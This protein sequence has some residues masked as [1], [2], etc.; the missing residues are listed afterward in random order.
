MRLPSSALRFVAFLGISSLFFSG[1]STELDPN[2]DYKETMVI[3]G[4][5]DPSQRT[6]YIKVNKAFLNTNTNALTIAANNPDSTT[7]GENLEVKLQQLRSDSSLIQEFTLSPFDTASKE[8]G[9]FFGP[10]QRL[11]RTKGLTLDQNAI[12][13]VV[14]VN[15]TS[16][17]TASGA[18]K[19][20]KDFNP[21]DGK[22]FCI[23]RISQ[24]TS[25][26]G[27]CFSD[28]GVVTTY[29]P[30]LKSA[31]SFD[32]AQNAAIYTISMSFDY[33][34][35]TDGV[36]VDKRAS[37]QVRNNFLQTYTKDPLS[38]PIDE[39][40]FYTNL[41]GI[42]N[43]QND[44][45]ST[46]RKPGNVYVTVTAGSESLATNHLVN[47]SFSIFSQVR[48]Q[49]DNIK[50]GTGLVGSRLAKTVT[51]VLSDKAAD[52]L[53]LSHKYRSLKFVK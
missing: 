38:I 14:A 45:P 4:L 35:S 28:N 25:P 31:I 39:N 10:T 15:K 13:R 12:Y 27:Q 50:N 5:L 40:Y 37:W 29:D 22:R 46:F 18:T 36:T 3:Y 6:H 16:G 11:Y 34:E 26:V 23:F 2:A 33:K 17:T 32:L 43:T 47:T 52:T 8:P 9:T 1:C 21:E 48:P 19:L 42:I 24:K 51:A 30:Q 41:L 20:V 44:K 49:F 7:Y 53:T